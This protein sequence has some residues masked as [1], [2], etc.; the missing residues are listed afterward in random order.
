MS[1]TGAGPKPSI[2]PA[3]RLHPARGPPSTRRSWTGCSLPRV[4]VSRQ[5]TQPSWFSGPSLE[6]LSRSPPAALQPLA[7][8]A[9][10]IVAPERLAVHEHERR[11]EHAL[12]HRLLHF[13]A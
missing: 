13:L 10:A 8:F 9:Q 1:S 11:A 12:V 7:H 3:S 6:A 4:P 5:L 2:S